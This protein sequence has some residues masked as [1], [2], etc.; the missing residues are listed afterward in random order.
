ME[1]LKINKSDLVTYIYFFIITFCK[2]IG[3]SGNNIFFILCSLIGVLLVALK[4]ISSSLKWNDFIALFFIISIGVVDFFIGG[5]TTILF[6]AIAL[7]CLKDTNLKNIIKI[8]FWTRIFAFILMIILSCGGIINNTIIEQYRSGIGTIKRY[9]FGYTHPN[10]THSAF[11]II[12]FLGGYLYGKKMRAIH[13][14]IIAILD[15][16]LYTFTISRTGFYLVLFYLVLLFVHNNI[17]AMK[18]IEPFILKYLFIVLFGLSVFSA[19]NYGKYD[20]INRLDNILTGRIHYLNILVLNYNPPLIGSDIYE[21]EVLFDNGYFSLLYEGGILACIYYLYFMRKS[22]KYL[23]RNKMYDEILFVI[24]FMIYCT[25]ESYYPSIL[26]NPAL[27]MFCYSIYNYNDKNMLE[28]NEDVR[29]I[30]V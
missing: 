19:Y 21:G 24:I 5:T 29:K 28:E 3:L 16:I 22:N 18:K 1:R 25:F 8:M 15:Y 11:A 30:M 10:F 17:K 13:Y 9:A 4:L 14:L 20:I 6:T 27:L 2:G 23:I 12:V 26:M 7:S